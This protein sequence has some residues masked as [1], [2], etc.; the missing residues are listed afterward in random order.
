MYINNEIDWI[1][2][3]KKK[4]VFI[5]GAGLIGKK[6]SYKLKKNGIMVEGF[7]DNNPQKSGSDCRGIKICSFSAYK[8]ISTSDSFVV[9]CSRHE[10]EIKQQMLDEGIF[11]FVSESQIDFGGGAD[12]YD[13]SYF[14]WQ[15]PLGEFG[16]AISY[17]MFSPYVKDTDTLVEFGS[18]G[19]YLLRLFNNHEKKGIEINDVAR[20]NAEKMGID[21]VKTSDMLSDHYADVIISTHVLEHVE[22]PLG[23]LRGLYRILKLGGRIVFYVPNESC[24]VEYERSEINNHLYTWNCLNIGNLF[25]AAG[26]FVHSVELVKEIWPSHWLKLKEEI[27]EEMFDE[28]TR[29]G[30]RAFDEN[31]CLIVAYR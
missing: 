31:N 27:S 28:L 18:G 7:I 16:A 24:D 11:T 13:E 23:E 21:S 30:G 25:K 14:E 29:I 3:L 8:S 9:I 26:F 4:R 15:K 10:R 19:G 22:N 5:F 1:S 2:F 17:K 6:C 20:G 12:Y